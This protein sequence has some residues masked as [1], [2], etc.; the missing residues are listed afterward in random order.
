[1]PK[2]V[3]LTRLSAVIRMLAGLT[4]RWMTPV[5]VGVVER[6]GDLRDDI[7]DERQRQRLVALEERL[8]VGPADVLHGDEGD[9][10]LA[11]LHHVV[12]GDDV[13]VGEDA[14]ALRLADE[15]G[16]ELLQLRVA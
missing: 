8:E 14:G 11:L 1:M 13:G 6:I 5:G 9:A 10:V 2:S 7:D 4:S 12:D 3:I 16:P 15:A